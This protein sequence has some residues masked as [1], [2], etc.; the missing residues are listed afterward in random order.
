MKTRE[1]RG[2]EIRQ[3]KEKRWWV[4]SSMFEAR[5][6]G[7]LKETKEAI[8]EM[9]GVMEEFAEEIRKHPEGRPIVAVKTCP[10]GR[11]R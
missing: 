9:E 4:V 2:Y 11:R 8:K 6:F 7:T 5:T 3:D 10:A 1:Y